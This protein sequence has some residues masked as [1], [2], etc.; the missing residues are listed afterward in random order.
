[1]TSKQLANDTTNIDLTIFT[2]H[3]NDQYLNTHNKCRYHVQ[4]PSLLRIA[5]GLKYYSL[6]NPAKNLHQQYIFTNFTTTIYTNILDDYIHLIQHHQHQIE[7]IQKEFI[8]NRGFTKCNIKSCN[9][10]SRHHRVH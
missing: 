1:M 8:Q 10:T 7:D 5:A 2:S 6:L 4:C 9:Y 3:Q